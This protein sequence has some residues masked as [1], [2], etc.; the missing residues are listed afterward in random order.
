[1]THARKAKARRMCCL[2][3]SAP[4]RENINYEHLADWRCN[5]KT[6]DITGIIVD[7]SMH[8]HKS[9]GPGLLESVYQ[10]LLEHELKKRGLNVQAEIPIPLKW[11]GM[12]L[13]L[14]FRADLLVENEVIVELKSVERT[15]PL[16]RKQLLTY[17][18]VSGLQVGLLVNFG[19]ALLK[20]GIHRVVCG[21]QDE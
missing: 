15:Q 17:L 16:H 5:M 1:M 20:N 8:I 9:L 11:D 18:K 4:P 6:N 21:F 7:A 12:Q 14:G 2:C 19:E 3:A 10:A 13:D